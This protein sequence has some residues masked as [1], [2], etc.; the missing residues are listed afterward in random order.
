VV[1]AVGE[2]KPA[3]QRPPTDEL[4]LVLDDAPV[5]S[6]ALQQGRAGALQ[7]A[8]HEIDLCGQLRQL[9]SPGQVHVL[10]DVGT[11][12]DALDRQAERCQ[13]A[14]DRAVEVGEQDAEGCEPGQHEQEYDATLGRRGP[15]L[16]LARRDGAHEY[17]RASPRSVQGR[18]GGDGPTVRDADQGLVG[19]FEGLDGAADVGG[20]VGRGDGEDL[21]LRP[22]RVR[23]PTQRGALQVL[24]LD[25]DTGVAGCEA[26]YRAAGYEGY[27]ARQGE[28]A[29]P[30][31]DARS[32]TQGSRKGRGRACAHGAK[33]AVLRLATKQQGAVRSIVGDAV[34]ARGRRRGRI[35]V[36]T[37]AGSRDVYRPAHLGPAHPVATSP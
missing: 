30:F 8:Q 27:A 10:S 29:A 22:D 25:G 35:D 11:G 7:R 2:R 4:G 26:R 5:T 33:L 13:A 24:D 9:V 31:G 6:L 21:H 1:G 36:V 23:Q 32:Q 34:G 37:H 16:P 19:V 17:S 3:V 12:A 14:Q 18:I 20:Q 15:R 28:S